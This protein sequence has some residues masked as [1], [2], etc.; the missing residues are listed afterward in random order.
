MKMRSPSTLYP[1]W[2][3]GCRM[4][5]QFLETGEIVSVHGVKGEVR[6]NP[7]SDSPQYLCA[8]ER[9]YL[10]AAGT[11]CIEAERVRAHGNIVIAKL[12]GV[13][14]VEEAVR[15]RGKTLF[16]NREDSPSGD[17]W[18]VQDLMGLEVLDVDSGERY[19]VL[20]QVLPTGANDVY[21][22][23]EPGKPDKLIPAIPQVVVDVDVDGG[24]MLI[25]PL[26]GLFDE[27]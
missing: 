23:S 14:S 7:W 12:R 10:D 8:F 13:D 4:K 25:R 21:Q 11:R 16:I 24:R 20:T 22:I 3:K 15:L 18:F 26:E 19:G 1:R 27:D 6:I 2:G 9:F 17:G 5:K